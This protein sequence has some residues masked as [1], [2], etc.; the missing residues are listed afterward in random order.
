MAEEQHD[1][2]DRGNDRGGPGAHHLPLAPVTTSDLSRS[3]RRILDRVARGER[4]IVYCHKQ[5]VATLQPLDGVVAQPFAAGAHDIYGNAIGSLEE[6]CD[7][8]S[9]TQRAL[10][11]TGVDRWKIVP[12]RV[13][14]RVAQP[15][16]WGLLI[17][18]IEEM[19]LMGLAKRTHRG[20]ELTGRGMMLRETLLQEGARSEPARERLD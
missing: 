2:E 9:E 8:L 17:R 18:S 13:N 10:L 20:W 12:G 6:E 11:T 4:F 5:P 14:P 1:G 15:I 16:D 19:G 7:K 3:P